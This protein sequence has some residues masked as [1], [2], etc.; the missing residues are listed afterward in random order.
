MDYTGSVAGKINGA[1]FVLWRVPTSNTA[2][3]YYH[4]VLRPSDDGTMIDGQFDTSRY[5]KVSA[6][7]IFGLAFVMFLLGMAF[8]AISQ[9]GLH[10]GN[11]VFPLGV[12]VVAGI[13]ALI[14]RYC[15]WLG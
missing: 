3:F 2:E 13:G 8:F 15:V 10:V 4:G 7:V 6:I 5:T 11:L 12:L 9:E 1:A 14:Y